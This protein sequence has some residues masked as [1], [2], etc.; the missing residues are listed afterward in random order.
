[1]LKRASILDLGRRE[2]DGTSGDEDSMEQ[3]TDWR[4]ALRRLFDDAFERDWP[5]HLASVN[6]QY[7]IML[8]PGFG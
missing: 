5:A 3:P 8:S 2:A 4:I 1:M 7:G 6:R